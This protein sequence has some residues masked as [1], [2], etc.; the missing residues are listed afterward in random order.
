MTARTPWADR[1]LQ[2]TRSFVLGDL[3]ARTFTAE[4]LRARH[5]SVAEREVSPDDLEA[6][7]ND[8]W[9]CI[10]MHNDVADLREPDE[11]DDAQLR[12]V[13]TGYLA[14][15]DAGTWEPDPRWAG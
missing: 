12:E 5:R 4:L 6:L 9:F 13:L 10:D 15:W 1:E 3:D 11:F 7:L 2:V 8:I 14:S